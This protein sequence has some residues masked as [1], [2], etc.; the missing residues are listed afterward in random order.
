MSLRTHKTQHT[1]QR[2]WEKREQS[3]TWVS[4]KRKKGEV[5]DAFV[6][7]SVHLQAIESDIPTKP[8]TNATHLP[9]WP[10]GH[11]S[12]QV[13][14]ATFLDRQLLSTSVD[15]PVLSQ[16]VC[17]VQFSWLTPSLFFLGPSFP[18]P[19]PI[20]WKI[21]PISPLCG[22]RAKREKGIFWLALTHTHRNECHPSCNKVSNN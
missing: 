8:Q 22:F 14:A 6:L 15:C 5:C 12:L 9:R 19:L 4:S 18:R 2:E 21:S 11:H 10:T 16:L 17:Y 20:S 13:L 3:W 1:Q 7:F